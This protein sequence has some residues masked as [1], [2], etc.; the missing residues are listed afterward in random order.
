MKFSTWMCV[1]VQRRRSVRLE[2]LN[3]NNPFVQSFS[4]LF[5]GSSSEDEDA[6]LTRRLLTAVTSSDDDDVALESSPPP[7]AQRRRTQPPPPSPGT[8]KRR[9]GSHKL[10]LKKGR[11]SRRR[12]ESERSLM[13]EFD[14]DPEDLDSV[15][16]SPETRSHFRTLFEQENRQLLNKF[17]EGGDDEEVVDDRDIDAFRARRQSPA[18]SPEEAYLRIGSN[19]RSA[20]KKRLP[21]VN[22]NGKPNDQN[23]TYTSCSLFRASSRVLTATSATS[24][25]AIRPPPTSSR[26]CP[27][28]RG[29]WLTP[30][31]PTTPSTP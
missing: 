28:T 19:L 7:P 5:P 31:R 25:P 1:Q 27:A 2:T 8:P 3:H 13:A 15:D 23:L 17:M 21:W 29:S 26:A 30:A 12:Y 6:R 22:M 24:S 18:M 20:L 11:K 14:L 16:L 10:V 4:G 9:L